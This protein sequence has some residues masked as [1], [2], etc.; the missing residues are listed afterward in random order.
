MGK[1]LVIVLILIIFT[2]LGIVAYSVFQ[3]Q[4]LIKTLTNSSATPKTSYSSPSAESQSS[5]SPSPKTTPTPTMTIAGLQENIEA[6]VN[7]KN[8]AAIASYVTKPKVNFSLMSSECCQPQTPDEAAS[9][10]NYITEGVPMD[11]N[12]ESVVVKNLKAKN[13]QLANTFIGISKAQEHSAAFTIDSNNKISAIQ[14]SVS[15]KLYEQ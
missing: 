14:L 2:L 11:F 4:K 10:M 13:P 15:W 5:A 7:S 1:N 6:A 12:Q 3:N 8:Y 9:Q